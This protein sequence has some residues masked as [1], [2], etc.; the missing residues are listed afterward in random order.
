MAVAETWHPTSTRTYLYARP[1]ELGQVFDFSLLKSPGS[2]TSSGG[3]SSDP[4]TTTVV[5]AGD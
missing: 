2:E 3:S 4:S 1:D 5:R